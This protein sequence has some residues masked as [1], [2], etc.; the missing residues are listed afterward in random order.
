MSQND[1]NFSEVSF[2][3]SSI[4]LHDGITKMKRLIPNISR[5]LYSSTL[6]SW[7]KNIP[8]QAGQ[9]SFDLS[10]K[11]SKRPKQSSMETLLAH[12]GLQSISSSENDN[13][14][15]NAPL[16]PPITFATTF[17][18]PPNGDYGPNGNIYSRIQNPTRT[19]L[20]QTL[21]ELEHDDESKFCHEK[22]KEHPLSYY[23]TTYASGMAAISSILLAHEPKV[24]VIVPDDVYHGVPS[25]LVQ[26]L[27]SKHGISYSSVDMTN[28]SKFERS[29][30]DISNSNKY[31]S[32]VIWLESPSNPLCKVTDIHAICE[33]VKSMPAVCE[34][35]TIVV[36]S[37]WAP[38]CI[39]QPLMVGDF[40]QC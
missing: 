2:V 24:H 29:L 22:S 7:N 31:K 33:L 18:R 34:N 11:E 28:L 1:L 9:L 38:P 3:L 10:Q 26:A 6:S 19:L 20:E 8:N 21:S 30:S 23:C 39:T 32:V 16:A 14:S 37:T 15:Q 25:Q 36:D 13:T 4:V 17:E 40:I 27:T 12:A 5:R 35:R